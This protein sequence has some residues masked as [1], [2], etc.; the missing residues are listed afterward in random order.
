M[1]VRYDV[2]LSAERLLLVAH[3][4]LGAPLYQAELREGVV[5][6]NAHDPRLD[7]DLLA[8]TIGDFVLANWPLPRLVAA[9]AV[10]AFEVADDGARRT[11]RDPAG[12]L[13][14]EIRRT[15]AS[16]AG[17]LEIVHH[18]APLRVAIQTLERGIMAP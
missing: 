6:V 15:G 5:S 9:F 12:V 10:D 16:G 7:D 4:T 11:L 2:E 18:D 8:R 3:T 17:A 14:L 13:L 1:V